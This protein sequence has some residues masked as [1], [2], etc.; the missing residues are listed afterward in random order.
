MCGGIW[1][2]ISIADKFSQGSIEQ[3]PRKEPRAREAFNVPAFPLAAGGIAQFDAVVAR[4]RRA[5]SGIGDCAGGDN[6]GS[7]LYAQGNQLDG[8]AQHQ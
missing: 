2:G 7:G 4:G 6:L 3:V 1:S 8:D 5:G